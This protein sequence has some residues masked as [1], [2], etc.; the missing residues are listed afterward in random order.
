MLRGTG[1][2]YDGKSLARGMKAE[3][4]SA[5]EANSH[6]PSPLSIQNPES[7]T[8]NPV[9]TTRHSHPIRVLLKARPTPTQL[10]DRLAAPV[11]AGLELYMDASDLANQSQLERLA[12]QLNRLKPAPD[13]VYVVEGPLRS[14]DGSFFDLSAYSE[15]NRECVR[16]IAWLAEAIGAEAILVHAITPMALDAPLG[17][18]LHRA[19]LESSLPMVDHYV[20]EARR[21]G[22]TPLLENVPPVAR[23]REG[24]YMSPII[25]MRAGDL[26]YFATRFPG[27]KVTLD[28]S[29]AQLFLNGL[30]TDPSSVTPELVPLVHYLNELGDT[31]DMEEYLKQLEP[32][33]FEAHISNARGLLGEGLPYYEGDLEL[34]ALTVRLA[35]LVRYLVTETIEPD[36]D[37]G[38]YMREAQQRLEAAL[39]RADGQTNV[40]IQEIPLHG[41]QD[42]GRQ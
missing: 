39:R 20:E 22:L 15:A 7:G 4:P 40:P 21:R 17:E 2:M 35:G 31:P 13:F 38:I 6:Q 32:H 12:G 27:L 14:L 18:A 19:K 23:Q 11:P 8:Q 25:G 3:V 1:R 37:R 42:E 24:S 29:H 33:L 34:D 16:R 9:P 36:P 28:V 5:A 10:A 26:A 41:G 30:R